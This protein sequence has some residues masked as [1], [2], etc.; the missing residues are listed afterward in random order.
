MTLSMEYRQ[1]SR[2]FA[3]FLIGAPETAIADIAATLYRRDEPAA[4]TRVLDRLP[5][6]ALE[7]RRP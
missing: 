4:L 3:A 7:F 6:A 1:P 5:S 2:D